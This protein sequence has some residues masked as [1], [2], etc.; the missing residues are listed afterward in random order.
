MRSQTTDCGFHAGTS[1]PSLSGKPVGVVCAAWL[2][3]Q[4]GRVR[5]PSAEAHRQPHEGPQKGVLTQGGLGARPTCMTDPEAEAQVSH[6]QGSDPQTR[7]TKARYSKPL[8][9]TC[10]TAIDGIQGMGLSYMAGSRS[11]QSENG[12]SGAH[13]RNLGTP[14]APAR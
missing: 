8:G 7:V 10:Y 3:S 14:C 12:P 5:G 11:C 1:S 6:P 9:D 4:P 2:G 13:P